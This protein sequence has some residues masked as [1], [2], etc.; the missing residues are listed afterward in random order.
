M[1]CESAN[2]RH[3]ASARGTRPGC[4]T[5]TS[6][7]ECSST[8][9]SRIAG[10]CCASAGKRCLFATRSASSANTMEN[11][12]CSR[13][14]HCSSEVRGGFSGFSRRFF[15]AC[16]SSGRRRPARSSTAAHAC[17]KTRGSARCAAFGICLS[18]VPSARTSKGASTITIAALMVSTVSG[19]GV[20]TPA[21]EA[22]AAT[23]SGTPATTSASSATSRCRI[24]PRYA[25][26][27][28]SR[29]R[30]SISA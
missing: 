27:I 30:S 19:T 2:A 26:G 5:V 6:R 9:A 1:P 8:I 28:A 29:R 10:K 11:A 21:A 22:I 20:G 17:L 13:M 25:C 3:A 14:P 24:R 23:A 4:G 7:A 15:R 12:A 18:T 16:C